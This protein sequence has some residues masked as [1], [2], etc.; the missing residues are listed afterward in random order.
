MGK[1]SFAQLGRYE[2]IAR[3]ATGGMAEILLA[4]QAGVGNFSRLVVVKRILPHLAEMPRFVEMFLEE[5]RLAAL[6]QHPNV[7]QI[8]D[9]DQY[10]GNHFIAMEFIDGLSVGGLCRRMRQQGQAVP[11][12]VAGEIIAQACDG[13]HAAHELRDPQDQTLGLVHRDISPQNLMMTR[14]GLVKVVDFGIAKAKNSS[15]RTRTGDIK[16]KH[17]YMSPEQIQAEPLDRRTDIFSLGAIFAE[18]LFGQRL[19]ERSS[20][21]ATFKAITEEPIPLMT[22]LDPQIPH[23]LSEVVH[24]A[25]QQKRDARFATASEMGDAVRAA[26]EAIGQRTSASTV[27]RYLQSECRDLLE[28]R[29]QA[30]RDLAQLE[31][32][33]SSPEQRVRGF[34]ERNG[35]YDTS[36]N[37]LQQTNAAKKRSNPTPTPLSGPPSSSQMLA[38]PLPKSS[39]PDDGD[40][41]TLV[42]STRTPSR[43][44]KRADSPVPDPEPKPLTTG[45]R[46][47][48]SPWHHVIGTPLLFVIVFSLAA[49]LVGAAYWRIERLNEPPGP[50]LYY[51]MTPYFATDTT[52]TAFEPLRAYLERRLNRQLEIVVS[53]DYAHLRRSIVDNTIHFASMSPMLFVQTQQEDPNVRPLAALT[54]EGSTTY[55]SYVVTNS[56]SEIRSVDQ[57]AGKKFCYVDPGST[58]GYLL[59]RQHLRELGF[60]PDQFL[61]ETTFL[62]SHERVMRGILD[63][64]CDAGAVNSGA[65]SGAP[66]IGLESSR[67]RIISVSGEVPLDVVCASSKVP[68]R[69]ADQMKRALLS[70]QPARDVGQK[71]MSKLI[72]INGFYEPNEELYRPIKE[73]AQQEGLID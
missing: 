15:V 59:P 44:I 43:K 35:S 17:P 48:P 57:L 34:D 1:K 53:R 4:R 7:V 5:A 69:T 36:A 18:L 19:F 54:Y 27:S 3:L 33:A 65:L 55:Q 49:A 21:L 16:G 60:D 63:G 28:T 66:N 50:P 9:V 25:L 10:K 23:V 29:A 14:S 46:P 68:A 20:D 2:L 58:S 62:G 22:Q 32:Y 56:N 13:L 70:F 31:S 64:D 52:K 8:H 51:A 40:G 71:A 30:I 72:R 12:A 11:Y 42:E 26:L 24:L 73:A 45:N 37:T 39:G 61:G 38:P 41:P 6:I 67:L 47:R